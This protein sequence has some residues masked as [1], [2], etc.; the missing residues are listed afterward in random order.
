M[1]EYC[2]LSAYVY[3]FLYTEE[4]GSGNVVNETVYAFAVRLSSY[5]RTREVGRALEKLEKRFSR[6]LPT[7]HVDPNSIDERQPWTI[8]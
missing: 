5:G 3:F 2:T 7:S 4:S 6:A 1:G 8:S